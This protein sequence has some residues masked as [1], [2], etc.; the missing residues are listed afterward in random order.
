MKTL[1]SLFLK[2]LAGLLLVVLL[3]LIIMVYVNRKDEE[4]SD[5]S[6]KLALITEIGPAVADA[7]NAFVFMLGFAAPDDADAMAAGQ[8]RVDKLRKFIAT[9][10]ILAIPP[11]TGEARVQAEVGDKQLKQLATLCRN[12]NHACAGE[13]QRLGDR[14]ELWTKQNNKLIHRYESLLEFHQWRELWPSEPRMPSAPFSDV[15]EGQRL[16][17][18]KAWL[19]AGKGQSAP[20]MQLLE[21]DLQFWRVMLRESSSAIAKLIAA[22]GIE[23]HFALGNLVVRRTQALPKGWQVPFSQAER[24]MAKVMA[25][26]WKFFN[27]H[28]QQASSEAGVEGKWSA[29]PG[30]FTFLPQATSNAYAERM[31]ALGKAFDLDT[32]AIPSAVEMLAASTKSASF[33][34]PVGQILLEVGDPQLF[35]KYGYQVA[36]L[37][38][39]RRMAVLACQLRGQ[40]V[41]TDGALARLQGSELRTP[42]D[43]SSYSWNHETSALAFHR[44]HSGKADFQL[45]Y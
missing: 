14:I 18:F 28:M 24:T 2:A 20:A 41:G 9:A 7:E 34:N 30:R 13:M 36:D 45:I 35:S 29:L 44:P 3:F 33:Y 31:R 27:Q 11:A 15:L 43:E 19:H 42:Y 37:E 16:M 10:D 32:A 8:L 40:G 38:G 17:L 23:Q 25:N 6:R 12:D 4:A 1:K 22:R 39:M 21:K 26:E 5:T